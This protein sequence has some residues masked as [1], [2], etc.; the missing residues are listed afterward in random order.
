MVCVF[1]DKYDIITANLL[2]FR[3]FSIARRVL[4]SVILFAVALLAAA[5]FAVNDAAAQSSG[6]GE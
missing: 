1:C 4:L 5:I 3:L 2:M 6:G